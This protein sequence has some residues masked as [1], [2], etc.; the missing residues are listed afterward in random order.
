M[1]NRVRR[2]HGVHFWKIFKYEDFS[3]AIFENGKILRTFSDQ[4]PSKLKIFSQNLTVAYVHIKYH[5]YQFSEESK[6]G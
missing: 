2:V 6:G 1:E 5:T 3:F 4:A